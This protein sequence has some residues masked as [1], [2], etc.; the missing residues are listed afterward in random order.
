MRVLLAGATGAIGVPLVRDLLAGG[1][2]SGEQQALHAVDGIVLRYGAFYGPSANTASVVELLK[3]RR[4]PTP[5][6]GGGTISWV[7]VDDAARP[8]WRRLSR[9]PGEASTTLWTTS[10]SAGAT[11]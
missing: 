8:P 4:L 2:R 9:R 3:R 11:S 5:R 1:L 7:Y 6:G 10:R